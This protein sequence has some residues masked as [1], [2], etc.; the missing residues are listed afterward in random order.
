MAWISRIL[1]DTLALEFRLL[2]P[3]FPAAIKDDPSV[4]QGLPKIAL[5]TFRSNAALIMG[6][7]T[8][9]KHIVPDETHIPEQIIQQLDLGEYLM[10]THFVDS[11]H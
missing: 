6:I 9:F 11:L 2:S 3:C 1:P 5:D 7:R 8:I 4:P 10:D